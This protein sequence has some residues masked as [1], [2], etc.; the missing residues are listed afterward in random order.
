MASE[1]TLSLMIGIGVDPAPRAVMEALTE[2]D[3]TIGAG[4]T[5]PERVRAQVRHEQ[6]LADHHRA[7]AER[8]F[9]SAHARGRSRRR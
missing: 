4:G 7:A 9:G 1:L 2:V 8:L 3:V 5:S 6:A